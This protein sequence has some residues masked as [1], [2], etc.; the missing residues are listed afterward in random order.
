MPFVVH[1]L[2][3]KIHTRTNLYEMDVKHWIRKLDES[4]MQ[5]F[6]PETTPILQLTHDRQALL[7]LADQIHK[8]LRQLTQP[9]LKEKT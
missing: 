3:Q 9:E 6:S 2:C 5:G 1:K 4:E 8:S 7:E